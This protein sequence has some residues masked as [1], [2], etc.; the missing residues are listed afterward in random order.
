MSGAQVLWH[1]HNS[2]HRQRASTRSCTHRLSKRTNFLPACHCHTVL[3]AELLDISL[4]HLLSLFP[5]FSSSVSTPLSA[6]V[7]TDRNFLCEQ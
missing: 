3:L 1:V 7:H 2:P 5:L 6:Q 4:N